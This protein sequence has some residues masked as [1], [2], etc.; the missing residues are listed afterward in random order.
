MF[1]SRSGP[2]FYEERGGIVNS[3]SSNPKF[4]KNINGKRE[5]ITIDDIRNPMI[6]PYDRYGHEYIIKE[7]EPNKFKYSYAK[8]NLN[9]NYNRNRAESVDS[10]NTLFEGN[11]SSKNYLSFM[12]RKSRRTKNRKGRKTLR[13][14]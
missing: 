12:Q 7:F 3:R 9:Q 11:N 2:K 6:Q 5:R 1:W 4:F 8:I 10:V 14:K 13:R